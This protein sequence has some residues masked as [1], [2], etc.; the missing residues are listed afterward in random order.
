MVLLLVIVSLSCKSSEEQR[1]LNDLKSQNPDF[2]AEA[3]RRLGQLARHGTIPPERAVEILLPYTKDSNS[4][5]RLFALGAVGD[6]DKTPRAI[7]NLAD[8]L[9]D[10]D[11]LV[12]R[13]GAA[14]LELRA[15]ET[16]SVIP[17]MLHAQFDRDKNVR[18]H[19]ARALSA[20]GQ[21]VDVAL[22][23]RWANL[24]P[25]EAKAELEA[26]GVRPDKDALLDGATHGD[27]AIV[28][29]LLKAGIDPSVAVA[30][31]WQ[32]SEIRRHPMIVRVLAEASQPEGR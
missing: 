28:I 10:P 24:T 19:I 22:P 25:N 6:N 3:A 11:V 16:A 5:V 30:N 2:R 18:R 7:S 29:L 8:A 15:S 31:E 12:R 1:L 32:R 20:H 21:Q 26:L 14:G 27:I 17:A 9:K 23:D 4:V 13:V